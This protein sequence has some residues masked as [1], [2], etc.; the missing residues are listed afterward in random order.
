L[1]IVETQLFR[2]ESEFEMTPFA[3]L[4][5]DSLESLQLL[6][7]TR[8]AGGE[9]ANVELGHLVAGTVAGIF[10]IDADRQGAAR[11]NSIPAQLQIRV[12]ES[13]IT[14]AVPERIKRRPRDVDV[15]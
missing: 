4:Q 12:S 15:L 6:D 13:R 2:T 8:A 9:V 1:T 3:G 7:R 5:G 10:H 11:P 14:Q